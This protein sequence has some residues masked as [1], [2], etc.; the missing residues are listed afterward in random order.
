MRRFLRQIYS[1]SLSQLKC[2]LEDFIVSLVAQIPLPVEGGRPFHVMLDAALISSTSRAMTAIM[3]D[4][5]HSRF[6]PF[7][8]L[9]FAAP[10]RCLSVDHVLA[11]FALILREAK[12]L[13]V[14]G[15]NAL[16][17]ETMETFRM[18]LFP[19]SWSSC[20]ISR[21]PYALMGVLEAPGGFMVGLNMETNVTDVFTSFESDAAAANNTTPTKHQQQQKS[22]AKNKIN[23]SNFSSF[24][25]NISENYTIPY[26]TYIVDLSSNNVHLFNGTEPEVLKQSKIDQLLK[27]L[28]VGPKTRLHY[29]LQKVSLEYLIGPQTSGLEE[30]DSAFDFQSQDEHQI[31]T[32][33][34]ESFPT[35]LIRDAFLVFMIELLGNYATYIIPPVEDMSADTYRTFKEEFYVDDYLEDADVSLRPLLELLLETQMFAVLLQQRSE[36]DQYSLVFFENAANLLRELGLSAGGHGIKNT[37][38]SSQPVFETPAPLYQLLEAESKWASLTRLMQQQILTDHANEQNNNQ[39]NSTNHQQQQQIVSEFYLTYINS[40][41]IVSPARSGM[42]IITSKPTKQLITNVKL[43]DLLTMLSRMK[44]SLESAHFNKR[45]SSSVDETHLNLNNNIFLL[46]PSTMHCGRRNELDN[47]EDLFLHDASFGALAL[48]GPVLLNQQE[49]S[50]KN[51]ILEQAPSTL[52]N[53]HNFWPKF[54]AKLLKIANSHIHRRIKDLR[55]ARLFAIE[56]VF[57]YLFLFRLYHIYFCTS[58]HIHSILFIYNIFTVSTTI[59]IIDR[60]KSFNVYSFST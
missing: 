28:P 18:L 46:T 58:L 49:V 53:Y 38:N 51:E 42:N 7:M 31:S 50:V 6:F 45:R 39:I 30:F 44:P 13:F 21:L 57:I 9:D 32:L 48:P 8:D 40:S 16:L 54:D 60:S 41:S 1:L 33:K 26:G 43:I 10:L 34:W 20:F 36:G 23:E 12:I 29:T 47:N 11:V 27:S 5:P 37:S 19:L 15:S 3:F 22:K 24:I 2:P 4:L 25:S 56:K 52:Y 17:T 14:C 55:R 35:L 59:K